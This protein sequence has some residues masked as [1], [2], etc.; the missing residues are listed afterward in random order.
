VGC[1]STILI[2]LRL[3]IGADLVELGDLLELGLIDK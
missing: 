1:V 2:T 3:V